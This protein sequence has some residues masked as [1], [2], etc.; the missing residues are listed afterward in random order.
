M[1][2]KLTHFLDELFESNIISPHL[3]KSGMSLY[4]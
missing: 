2:V 1:K 3:A 4:I